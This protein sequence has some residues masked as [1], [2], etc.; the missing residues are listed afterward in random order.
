M[1][2]ISKVTTQLTITKNK[3][4]VLVT[5]IA[6]YYTKNHCNEFKTI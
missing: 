2:K 1:N 3:I 5:C 4:K 6:C